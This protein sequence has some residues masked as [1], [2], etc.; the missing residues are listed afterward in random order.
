MTVPAATSGIR[1]REGTRADARADALALLFVVLG[2]AARLLAARRSFVTPDEALHLDIARKATVVDTYRAT[3]TNAHPP[4]FE[5]LLY[6]WQR[7]VGP[8]WQLCLL[9]AACGTAFLWAAYKWG[10]SLFGKSSALLMLALLAFLP[11]FVLLSSELRGYS[12]MLW[13]V[14][15]SLAALELA[16]RKASSRWL[17]VSAALAGLAL[18]S[19]YAALRFAIAAVVYGAARL[20]AERSDPRL[21]RVWFVSQ[22]AVAAVF[23]LLYASHVSKLRG[24]RLEQEAQAG[25]LR[26]SYFHGKEESALVFLGRQTAA[27]F[28][29]LFSTPAAAI[30]AG[31]LFVCGAALLVA[32]RQP[33]TILL[34]SPFVLAGAGGLL[35][36]YP[37]GGSRHSIDL[38]L[39]ACAAIGVAL[40]RL[41]RDRPWV[42]L[43][44]ATLIAPAGFAVSW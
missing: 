13:L 6:F 34:L 38:G 43:A 42:A 5:L 30:V 19:H 2:L 21:V 10:A 7:I 16:F 17:A 14:A 27:L 24:G 18:L 36:L 29:F 9:P 40:A 41:S 1:E 4:L 32:K 25:W 3:L 44:L 26:A 23:L 12:L 15:S 37:Y 22:A 35:R 31:L 20:R 11:S 39:F 33:S 8:G 28:H